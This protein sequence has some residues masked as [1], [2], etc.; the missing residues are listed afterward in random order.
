MAMIS[1]P[2][3]TNQVL[4]LDKVTFKGIKLLFYVAC[5]HVSHLNKEEKA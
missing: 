3:K 1:Y 4:K 5:R 2:K